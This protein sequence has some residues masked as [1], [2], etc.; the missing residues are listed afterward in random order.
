MYQSAAPFHSTDGKAGDSRLD[1]TG[2]DQN[3]WVWERRLSQYRPASIPV[4]L[5]GT[6]SYP[7]IYSAV[8]SLISAF[9]IKL[10]ATAIQNCATLLNGQNCNVQGFLSTL[11]KHCLQTKISLAGPAVRLH[12]DPAGALG[13]SLPWIQVRKQSQMLNS[14]K[15]PCTDNICE[16]L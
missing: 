15:W 4:C 1:Q 9:G 14:K 6:V 11:S 13:A 7:H 5:P 10:W 8:S 16:L 3:W 2:R 12:P